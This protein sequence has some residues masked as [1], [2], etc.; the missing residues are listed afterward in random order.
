MH[1]GRGFES[2]K[3]IKPLLNGFMGQINTGFEAW[4]GTWEIY[5]REYGRPYEKCIKER[6]LDQASSQLE[7]GLMQMCAKY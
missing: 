7:D 5:Q 6:I 3:G 1:V 4:R 2:L